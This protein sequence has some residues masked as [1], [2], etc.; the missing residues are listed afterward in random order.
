MSIDTNVLEN[1]VWVTRPV[2]MEQVISR[3]RPRPPAP[4]LKMASQSSAP[5]LTTGVLTKTL[6]RSPVVNQV[7]RAKIRSRDRNDVVCVGEDFIHLKEIKADEILSHVATKSDFPGRITAALVLGAPPTHYLNPGIKFEDEGQQNVMPPHILVLVLDSCELL[8]LTVQE[9]RDGLVFQQRTRTLPRGPSI[10][11]RPTKHLAVD[12]NQRAISVAAIDHDV[13]V[14]TLKT[15]ETMKTEYQRDTDKW[16]PVMSI[17]RLTVPGTIL[18]MDFLYPD[19]DIKHDARVM[20]SLIVA[21][22]R[23]TSKIFSFVW[24][25][26][27]EPSMTESSTEQYAQRLVAAK[28]VHES[29]YRLPLLM[30][31]LQYGP[32]FWLF[33]EGGKG[34]LVHEP[35]AA[36]TKSTRKPMEDGANPLHP[37]SS[38][39]HPAY[40]SWTRT[41]RSP[42]FALQKGESYYLTREDG[43]VR[44]LYSDTEI[45]NSWNISHT[46]DMFSNLGPALCCVGYEI[47]V[48]GNLT[49][50]DILIAG[51]CMG[52]TKVAKVGGWDA[53]HDGRGRRIAHTLHMLESHPDWTPL[54]DVAITRMPATEPDALRQRSQIIATRGRQPQGGLTEMRIGY[55]AAVATTTPLDEPPNV[56]RLI[57]LTSDS[58]ASLFLVVAFPDRTALILLN[59]EPRDSS[60][61]ISYS[62]EY[63]MDLES[64]TLAAATLA[65][66]RALQITTKAIRILDRVQGQESEGQNFSPNQGRMLE[67]PASTTVTAAAVCV[68]PTFSSLPGTSFAMTAQ[69]AASHCLQLGEIRRNADGSEIEVLGEPS[70]IN[71]TP[72]CI[73]VSVV[74]TSCVIVLGTASGMVSL[75]HASPDLKLLP[76]LDKQIQPTSPQEPLP[77]CESVL[78][79]QSQFGTIIEYLL[80]CGLRD[81]RLLTLEIELTLEGTAT[82]QWGKSQILTIG[83]APVALTPAAHGPT[84]CAFA[85]CGEDLLHLNYDAGSSS[86][87]KIFNTWHVERDATRNTISQLDQPSIDAIAAAPADLQFTSPFVNHLICISKSD[88]SISKLDCTL[89]R[90]IPRTLTNRGNFKNTSTPTRITYS[91]ETKSIITT[92][93]DARLIRDDPNPVHTP[94]SLLSGYRR[95]TGQL[96]ILNTQA[97][98]AMPDLPVNDENLEPQPKAPLPEP[99]KVDRIQGND[100]NTCRLTFDLGR[101][102]ERILALLNWKTDQGNFLV[103][104]TRSDKAAARRR[105]GQSPGKPFGRL[106]VVSVLGGSNATDVKVIKECQYSDPVYAI[107]SYGSNG[108][109]FT[110]GKSLK[111]CRLEADSHNQPRYGTRCALPNSLLLASTLLPS[112]R[113]SMYLPR[114]TPFVPTGTP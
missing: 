89:V 80:V 47:R 26:E 10:L 108:L 103:M 84:S 110:T 85:T 105:D 24:G 40:T 76:L 30:I 38:K 41:I 90:T 107:A 28:D 42:S 92:S 44:Y 60:L 104:G 63:D 53:A 97:Q 71:Q 2:P 51:G 52:N 56:T 86:G 48:G 73:S 36:P 79:L 3:N 68:G 67:V 34:L 14:I 65:S 113:L 109:I 112:N 13:Y 66:G 91:E 98:A 83:L 16:N 37:A 35:F 25:E 17:R 106:L 12:P 6:V 87:L 21:S 49:G 1:G 70:P 55:E 20:L 4:V 69:N 95:C 111:L 75:S 39:K 46:G 78:I 77:A 74:N 50:P 5:E 100:D 15:W 11:S 59:D 9:N 23:L 64:T 81:G 57:A 27:T 45:S 99:P 7:L 8:F 72:T 82:L 88:L 102:G 94:F 93:L 31:P 54:M 62:H 22:N 29:T 114:K 33:C 58:E 19:V 96:H 101:Q 32:K 18:K 43:D 61:E